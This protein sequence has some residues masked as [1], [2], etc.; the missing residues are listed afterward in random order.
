MSFGKG[1]NPSHRI[2][3]VDNWTYLG[4]NLVH[5]QH[6]GYC[7]KD[8]LSKFYRAANFILCVEGR[9]DDVV[10]LRLLEAHCVPILSYGVEVLR[11]ADSKQ[12]NKLG[13]AYNSV[14]RK[15]FNYSWRESVSELQHALGRPTWEELVE[16]RQKDFILKCREFH[17]Q[18]LVCII[19][20]YTIT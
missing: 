12:R 18:S 1:A 2:E 8:T 19:N 3:W 6:F 16:K 14:F 5:S 11:I 15:S 4:V 20:A 13:V 7:I 9:S 17:S 10:M